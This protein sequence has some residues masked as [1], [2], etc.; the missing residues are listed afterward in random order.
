VAGIPEQKIMTVVYF[1]DVSTM[2]LIQESRIP[3]HILAPKM[4]VYRL[5]KIFTLTEKIRKASQP[6]NLNTAQNQGLGNRNTSNIKLF[7]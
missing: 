6:T 4:F 2:K 1:L 5:H 7:Q 3:I